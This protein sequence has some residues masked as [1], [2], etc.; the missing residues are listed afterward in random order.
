MQVPAW[1]PDKPRSV[2]LA[3]DLSSR[4]D[5]ALD[6]AMFLVREWSARLV[7][8]SVVEVDTGRDAGTPT[9]DRRVSAYNRIRR[10]IDSSD[11]DVTVEVMVRD[12]N[13]SEQIGAVADETGCSLIVTGTARNELFGRIILGSTVE[14]LARTSRLPLL[15]VHSRVHG[16]YARIVVASDFSASSR[17]ALDTI[18]SL[19]PDAQPAVFH[20]FDVPFLGLMDTQRDELLVHAKDEAIA[21]AKAFVSA[22]GHPEL[23]VVVAH[24]DAASRLREHADIHEIDLIVVASH[25]HSALYK[26][27]IGSVARRILETAPCDTL[28][29]PEPQARAG[30]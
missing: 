12:G 8:L 24:G 1:I 21:A 17:H 7:V 25:G 26:V 27:L 13:V 11:D 19:T 22:A 28:L 5:R 20:A 6:R 29:V 23:P 4:C 2:L 15:T 18:V 9:T 30:K 14:R 3:T 16:P 10:D